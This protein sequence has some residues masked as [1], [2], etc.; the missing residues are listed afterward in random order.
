MQVGYIDL[1]EARE[2][3][4]VG[5]SRAWSW[6][7]GALTQ[8][9]PGRRTLIWNDRDGDRFVARTYDVEHGSSDVLPRPVYAVDPGGRFM[10]SLNMARLDAVRPGYGYV[11]GSGAR[12]DERLPREDGIWRVDLSTGETE[13]MLSLETAV[14]FL[15]SRLSIKSR[16]KHWFKRYIYWFNHVKLSPSGERFTVKLRFRA[17]DLKSGWNDQMGVSLTGKTDGTDL[18]LLA[19]GT[20]HVIWL[21][22][23][24]LY[25]WQRD[26]VYLYDDER[27]EGRR[28]RQLAGDLIDHNVHI[29]HFPGTTD[30]F[31]F[32]TPYREQVSVYVYDAGAG[33][34]VKI[35]RF[36]NHTPKRGLFRCDLHP[37]PSPDAKK[38]VVTSLDDGGRQIYLLTR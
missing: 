25:L 37:V 28:R 17:H 23:D 12:L 32:D 8:W 4:P 27:P 20:S 13:L 31:V 38:I 10:L 11:E 29:R 18:R 22:T 21:D 34:H 33:E 14:R 35:A 36:G 24:R 9:I 2:W 1:E 3:T 6:Q 16:L 7:Q 30:R 15:R 19:R 5:E 26:G